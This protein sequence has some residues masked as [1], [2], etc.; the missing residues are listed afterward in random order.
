MKEH[1]GTI[2]V[3]II[4]SLVIIVFMALVSLAIHSSA[5]M[6]TVSNQTIQQIKDL[7]QRF[8]ILSKEYNNKDVNYPLGYI[9]YDRDTKIEYYISGG[10]KNTG[11]MSVLYNEKGL[12]LIYKG[13][14]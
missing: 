13:G 10:Y 11:T 5:N 12:P 2:C 8:V 1:I 14:E 9:V 7:E 4:I 3:T 6:E